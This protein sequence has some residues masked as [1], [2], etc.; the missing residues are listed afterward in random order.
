MATTT[1]T[2]LRRSLSE[3]IGDY[4][5]FAT[6]SDG[7]DAKTSL[8]STVLKNYA[9]G[10]DDGAFEEQ[11]FLGT[12]GANE[13]ESKRCALYIANAS[14]GPTAILQDALSNQTTSAD[15]LNYTATIQT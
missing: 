15:T 10:S 8:V 14:D 1:R 7:N 5:A 2:N 13:G 6:T 11:F 4:Q 3:A 12:S 9:G